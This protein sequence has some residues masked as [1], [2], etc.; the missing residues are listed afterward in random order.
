MNKGI[1]IAD[2]FNS[3]ICILNAVTEYLD[4]KIIARA[5]FTLVFV[6]LCKLVNN[7]VLCYG[8]NRGNEKALINTNLIECH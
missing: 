8:K 5:L 1:Y 4:K 3:I 6:S 2:N 7:N